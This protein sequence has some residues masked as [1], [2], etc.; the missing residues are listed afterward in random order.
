MLVSDA[1]CISLHSSIRDLH[2]RKSSESK[3]VSFFRKNLGVPYMK[4]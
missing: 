3:N 2:L 4:W 1:Y